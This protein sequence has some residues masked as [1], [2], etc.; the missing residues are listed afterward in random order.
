MR[1]DYIYVHFESLVNL[2][3]SRG[4]SAGDFMNGVL[5]RPSNILLING[6]TNDDLPIDSHTLF[7]ELSGQDEIAEYMLTGAKQL[8]WIDFSQ[9][10]SIGDLTDSDIADLLFMGHMGTHLSTPFSYK[11]QNDFVYLSLGENQVKTYYRRLKNFYS[12]LNLS[13]LRHAETMQNEHRM[14]FRRVVHFDEIPQTM[15]RE[16]IPVLSEGII[17]A[18]DQA[19]EQDRQYRIPILMVS[20]SN[21]APTLRSRESLY[22]KAA[23]IAVLKYNFKSRHWHMVIS[24]PKAFDSD[25]LY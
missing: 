20:D 5:Q 14:M 12:V 21:L 9:K 11:L 17:F 18:F 19:F 23:Q 6:Q 16:L 4:I 10:E 1:D 15:I 22:N 25:N 3:Y 7:N 2:I 24:D 8:R 13:I